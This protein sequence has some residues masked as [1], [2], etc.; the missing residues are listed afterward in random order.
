M[1]RAHGYSPLETIAAPRD[2]TVTLRYAERSVEVHATVVNGIVRVRLREDGG[3][4]RQTESA[5]TRGITATSFDPVTG[6]TP[7]FADI[8]DPP[9]PELNEVVPAVRAALV[10]FE[11]GARDEGGTD[12]RATVRIRARRFAVSVDDQPPVGQETTVVHLTG[13]ACHD[14][15]PGMAHLAGRDISAITADHAYQAGRTTVQRARDLAAAVRPTTGRRTVILAPAAAAV[16]VHE[17]VGHGLEAGYLPRGAL[18]RKRGAPLTHP[19]LNIV[20]DASDS[21][22]WERLSVDEEGTPVRPTP[23]VMSGVVCGAITDRLSAQRL[24][25]PL[26]GNGRR[27]RWTE[28]SVAR[29][30][31]LR[32][33]AGPD[34]VETMLAESGDALLV[35]LVESG[36]ASVPTGEFTL[37]VRSARELRHGQPGRQLTDFVLAGG[38]DELRALDAIGDRPEP[39]YGLCGRGST[40]MPIS[41]VTPHLRMPLRILGAA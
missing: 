39:T 13:S 17:L 41:G 12:V 35:E 4:T 1:S 29:T 37:R 19:A 8:G 33:A 16:L 15:T 6:P 11:A 21:Q 24:G 20:E 34:H 40:W 9:L 2:E 32:V 38:L 7:D 36:E 26:S 18:W 31:H 28:R 3:M 27:S 14:G 5:G 25:E 30:R 22:A 23:L 10:G